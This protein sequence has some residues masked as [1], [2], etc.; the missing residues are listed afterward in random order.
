MREVMLASAS[1]RQL[2]RDTT[3]NQEGRSLG[4]ASDGVSQKEASAA[5]VASPA[6]S[7]LNWGIVLVRSLKCWARELG[8][9][10][11]RKTR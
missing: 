4:A 2:G 11:R 5:G 1:G 8:K 6:A 3:E 7:P 9:G 10:H